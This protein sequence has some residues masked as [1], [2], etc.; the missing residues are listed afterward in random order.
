MGS[1]M[2][3]VLMPTPS[4]FTKSVLGGSWVVISGVISSVTIVVTH[5]RALITPITT[6]HEPPSRVRQ[7]LRREG[8][9]RIGRLEILAST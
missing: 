7:F 2:G 1:Q 5:I 6:T 3:R 4:S 9:L 8:R